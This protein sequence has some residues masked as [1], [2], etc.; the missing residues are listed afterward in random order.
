MALHRIH[1]RL[2]NSCI[3]W[4]ILMGIM[5]DIQPF[6]N[7][8]NSRNISIVFAWVYEQSLY[9]EFID[10]GQEYYVQSRNSWAKNENVL[11]MCSLS[12]H[13]RM[14]LFLHQVCRNVSQ[15]WMWMG[16]VRMP[17]P[18]RQLSSGE[19]KELFWSVQISLLIQT[20][21]RFHWR[22][23]YYGLWTQS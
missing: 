18:V 23:S 21:T 8:G 5:L 9:I 3:F 7:A 1:F 12:G 10:A 16:A 14:S 4:R 2:L 15:Q 6:S 19:D 22:K 13:P 20:R 11:K 17:S